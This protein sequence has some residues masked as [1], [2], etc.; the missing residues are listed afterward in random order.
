M[1]QD[2]HSVR[3][4]RFRR[5]F[6]WKA[7]SSFPF[8]L[9][10]RR[11]L[12]RGPSHWRSAGGAETRLLPQERRT[13]IPGVRDAR[14]VQVGLLRSGSPFCLVGLDP[15]HHTDHSARFRDSRSG[16]LTYAIPESLGGY[17]PFGDCVCRWILRSLPSWRLLASP[18]QLLLILAWMLGP[19][20]LHR[21]EADYFDRRRDI[22]LRGRRRS[23]VMRL[24]SLVHRS[25]LRSDHIAA[26]RASAA[27][28]RQ[29]QNMPLW[30][31]RNPVM[32]KWLRY[33]GQLYNR[34]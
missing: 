1:H 16:S 14:R 11:P 25:H 2:R 33:P 18:R 23:E 27:V 19:R 34:R 7:T 30:T 20:M 21:L 3:F 29:R 22:S 15:P 13:T 4:F 6:F 10:R 26:K 28:R 8:R 31:H 17:R 24:N 5:S 9:P 12:S 32:D